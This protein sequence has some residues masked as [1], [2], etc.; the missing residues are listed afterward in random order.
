MR[1]AK[2]FIRTRLVRPLTIF[3]IVKASDGVLFQPVMGDML[4]FS[5]TYVTVRLL[6]YF[7]YAFCFSPG[8]VNL[9]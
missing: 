5:N 2:S 8:K 3:V 9:P 1:Q 7:R 6:K 4:I